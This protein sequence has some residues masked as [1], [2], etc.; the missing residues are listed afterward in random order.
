MSLASPGLSQS[1]AARLLPQHAP[2]G[3]VYDGELR[4]RCPARPWQALNGE[5]APYR[6][7]SY[8][9]A[10]HCI[11]S[12]QTPR[13][14]KS[15]STTPRLLAPTT[16]YTVTARQL[17]ECSNTNTQ[18][19]TR[20][21]AST[22]LNQGACKTLNQGACTTLNKGECRWLT[23]RRCCLCLLA[24]Y[25]AVYALLFCIEAIKSPLSQQQSSLNAAALQRREEAARALEPLVQKFELLV[26]A[27]ALV[28]WM[29]YYPF[30]VSTGTYVEIHT[31]CMAVMHTALPH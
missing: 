4:T 19:H 15:S 16:P 17:C 18:T 11:A 28:F 7:T 20:A 8:H 25:V 14:G 22:T 27:G 2:T 30:F 1:P 26:C 23:L 13:Q 10:S 5:A 31:H 21:R 24:L 12:P 9:I 3:G 29:S 6:I